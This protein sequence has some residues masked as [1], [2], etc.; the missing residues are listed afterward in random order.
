MSSAQS[1][2]PAQPPRVLSDEEGDLGPLE[3]LQGNM[4]GLGIKQEIAPLFF[5][6]GVEDRCACG[7]TK[8]Q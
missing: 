4:D 8:N 7:V 3:V 1:P 5:P 2:G 6:S